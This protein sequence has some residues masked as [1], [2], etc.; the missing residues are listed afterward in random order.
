MT[1]PRYPSLTTTPI[2]IAET[3]SLYRMRSRQAISRFNSIRR[4]R[5]RGAAWEDGRCDS[6]TLAGEQP[7][8]LVAYNTTTRTG[9]KEHRPL[10][11]IPSPKPSPLPVSRPAGPPYY[12][13]PDRYNGYS[14]Q[15]RRFSAR[16][17]LPSDTSAKPSWLSSLRSALRLLII[18]LSGAV[19]GM[20]VHTLQ[21]YRGNSSLDLRKGELPMTWPARTNL[22]PT[23]VLFSIAAANFLASVAILALSFKKSFRRPIRS[24][25]V[26]RIVA[27]SFGVI[28][29]VAAL[30]V[31]N[32]LD[33]ASKA[34]LGQYSCTNKNVMSNGRYQYR[35]VCSEQGVAFYIAIG[36]ASSEVLT[37]TTL[38][39]TAV[40]SA[41]Q[42][43]II[44]GDEKAQLSGAMNGRLA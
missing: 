22:A 31:Y 37:L 39:V 14:R 26:Y 4:D 17:Q 21:I 44:K 15:P 10:S 9:L 43:S 8:I 27:G 33:K 30:L 5:K 38:A 41:K 16:M 34:S 3:H 25:D 20:L 23:I 29:W 18:V 12:P 19:A 13:P 24:R 6:S 32:L 35:T 1:F 28:L 7:R 11:P 2:H 42:T 40:Q 36:A